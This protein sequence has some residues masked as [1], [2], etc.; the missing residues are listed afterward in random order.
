[1]PAVDMEGVGR[2]AALADPS[3]A[4]FSVIKSQP[5]AQS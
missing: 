5:P 4:L 1:M 3:G 2:M